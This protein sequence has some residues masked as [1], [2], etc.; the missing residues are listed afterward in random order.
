MINNI[1]TACGFVS[2]S[3]KSLNIYTPCHSSHD[4]SVQSLGCRGDCRNVGLKLFAPSVGAALTHGVFK[5]HKLRSLRLANPDKGSD[6]SHVETKR[7]RPTSSSNLK[8]VYMRTVISDIAV[9]QVV[10]TRLITSAI[11]AFVFR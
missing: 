5:T 1:I 8:S 4:T 2:G 11:K 7:I 6:S 3:F 9:Q 10:A